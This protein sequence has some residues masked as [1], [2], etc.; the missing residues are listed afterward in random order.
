M[1]ALYI[2]IAFLMILA[3]CTDDDRS[4]D[5]VDTEKFPY[6]ITLEKNP[7]KYSLWVDL[8]TEAGMYETLNIYGS[9][10]FI[11]PNNSAVEQYLN[12]RD[13]SSFTKK[14][15][16]SLVR[17][18][19]FPRQVT[20]AD[21]REGA[22]NDT[23]YIGD[24]VSV[25]FVADNG[26][27]TLLNKNCKIIDSDIDL[28]N[29]IMHETDKVLGVNQATI[30]TYIENQDG[31]SIF[32]QALQETGLIDVLDQVAITNN[33]NIVVRTYFTLMLIDDATFIAQGIEDFEALKTRYDSP[34]IELTD[35]DH[36]LRQFMEYHIL[37]GANFS[38]S[39]LDFAHDIESINIMSLLYGE[40]IN[41][42]ENRGKIRI[43]Y[44]E[45]G[46][47]ESFTSL[48]DGQRN[49]PFKNGCVHYINNL[50]DIE[51]LKP[52]YMV[53]D[54]VLVEDYHR[55]SI[56]KTLDSNNE[57]SGKDEKIAK[58][59]I[60]E[61]NWDSWPEQVEMT[62]KR[63]DTQWTPNGML[64]FDLGNNDGGWFE[65]QTPII[66]AGKYRIKCMT[67]TRKFG[68]VFKS[69][70]DGVQK[71]EVSMNYNQDFVVYRT[72]ADGITF[73]KSESHTIRLEY[74][75]GPATAFLGPILIEPL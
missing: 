1:K 39:M 26:T 29:G 25:D 5:F 20:K 49:F 6:V 17:N 33:S 4:A 60:K 22:V 3:A 70:V 59:V 54:P 23:N 43:N 40:G 65:V 31:I 55:I 72:L 10:T 15:L 73:D 51:S 53:F 8:I 34:G 7:E 58:G 44:V 56:H 11:T 18:H 42:M 9:Y 61:W 21:F 2:V 71:A 19:I 37:Q 57:F 47:E 66:P 74:K 46:E 27:K 32:K 13:L 14:E 24:Y 30:K 62:Y 63:Y 64:W 45:E 36:R 50:M 68:G 38:N 16:E 67:L 75:S 12:G 41:V 28:V 35:A 69:L 48:V 52:V